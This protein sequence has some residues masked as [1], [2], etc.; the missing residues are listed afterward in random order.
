MPSLRTNFIRLSDP[1]SPTDTEPVDHSIIPLVESSLLQSTVYFDWGTS[2]S[3][4]DM[5]YASQI[6]QYVQPQLDTRF[7]ESSG[8]G[9]FKVNSYT[10]L[11]PLTDNSI[12]IRDVSIIHSQTQRSI[13]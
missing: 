3:E 2:P 13:I 9:Y 10:R 6:P 7:A 1:P 5:D 12:P 11:G 8:V 4:V